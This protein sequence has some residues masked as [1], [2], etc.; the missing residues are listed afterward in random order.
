[1]ER[2]SPIF[3]DPATFPTKSVGPE[4]ELRFI[5]PKDVNLSQLAYVFDYELEDTLPDSAFDGI[6]SAVEAW[7]FRYLESTLSVHHRDRAQHRADQTRWCGP[8][9]CQLRQWPS[10]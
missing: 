2:F 8:D 3:E 5:Y 4:R 1:M 6:I 10:D 9:R 7:K